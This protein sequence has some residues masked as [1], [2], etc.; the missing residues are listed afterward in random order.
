MRLR[1]LSPMPRGGL[2]NLGCR[3]RA[4][5]RTHPF[6]SASAGA[7]RVGAS[8]AGSADRGLTANDSGAGLLSFSSA[9]GPPEVA[10]AWSSV[11]PATPKRPGTAHADVRF[12]LGRSSGGSIAAAIRRS[13]PVIYAGG[14]RDIGRV[15]KKPGHLL[16]GLPKCPTQSAVGAETFCETT[17]VDE[18][19]IAVAIGSD[20]RQHA[21]NVVEPAQRF[22]D[23]IPTWAYLEP[24]VSPVGWVRIIRSCW[25]AG[26]RCVC[27]TG[28]MP[29]KWPG[30]S[31]H[32]SVS[33]AVVRVR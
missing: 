28:S 29:P 16:I 13:L 11:F 6:V 1:Q 26:G 25:P 8:D 10:W 30:T 17:Q 4:A 22:D 21:G 31:I 27:H 20:D 7:P 12:A 5:V 19:D 18:V 2:G 24:V 15:R 9:T 33:A 3:H 14:F 32:D 23:G